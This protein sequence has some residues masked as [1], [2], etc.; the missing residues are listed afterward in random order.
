[1]PTKEGQRESA[2]TLAYRALQTLDEVAKVYAARTDREPYADVQVSRGV[3][4]GRLAV[5]EKME[6]RLDLMDRAVAAYD[7]ALEVYG[8]DSERGRETL[9]KRTP[10]AAYGFAIRHNLLGKARSK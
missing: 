5:R 6:D 10:V 8:R 1:M 2:K 9:E 3:I 7:A 4:L